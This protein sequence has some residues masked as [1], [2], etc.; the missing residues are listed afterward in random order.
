MPTP[1]F[2]Q[3]SPDLTWLGVASLHRFEDPAALRIHLAEV[4][5]TCALPKSI[6][7]TA[8][9]LN[10]RVPSKLAAH[11]CSQEH[12][13]QPCTFNHNHAPSTLT[14]YHVPSTLTMYPQ[15]YP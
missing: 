4:K 9:F 3:T 2:P 6:E 13:V 12:K 1:T 15:P 14:M 8:A 10:V 7:S 11:V 5:E